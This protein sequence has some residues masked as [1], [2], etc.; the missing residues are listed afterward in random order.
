MKNKYTTIGIIF[1]TLVLAGIAIFTA[2]KLYQTGTNSVAPNAPESKPAAADNQVDKNIPN[3]NTNNC[4]LSFKLLSTVAPASC[5]QT[6]NESTNPRIL[7]ASGLI[8]LQTGNDRGANGVCRKAACNSRTD[9]ICPIATA[10]PTVA[11][12]ATA[13]SQATSAPTV[14][15]TTAPVSQCSNACTSNSNCASGLMCYISNGSTSGMCRN[16]QCL[17]ETDCVCNIVTDQ[18]TVRPTQASLPTAGTSWP[19]VL[20]TGFGIMVVIGSLLLA[21]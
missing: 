16:T 18:P 9:C 20:G 8:C 6:C 3:P 4:S 10:S 21:L 7:C 19:T 13:T 5:N 11:P 12:T 14:A 2:I 15:P 17:S 1:A